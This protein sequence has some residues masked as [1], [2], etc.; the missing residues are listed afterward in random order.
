MKVWPLFVNC[1]RNRN[2]Y[3]NYS[4]TRVLLHQ[5]VYDISR[6]STS[7]MTAHSQ[8][9]FRHVSSSTSQNHVSPESFAVVYRF[10][11]I[12]FVRALSRLKLLQT[13][14]AALG[15]PTTGIL[16]NMQYIDPE[17]FYMMS[18]V[19]LFAC[20]MLYVMSELT[21]RAVGAIYIDPE[22]RLV[23]VSHLTFWGAR[24]NIIVPVDDI[25]PLADISEEPKNIYVKLK[26]YSTE[27]VLYFSIKY[28]LIFD[29][30][31][32]EL[33]FGKLEPRLIK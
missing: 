27:D 32:F 9:N 24:K 14:V 12:V 6:R 28:G 7:C 31:A 26:R 23:K 17:V 20:A 25:V 33:V 29:K 18:G 15:I 16:S 5:Y 30:E 22:R 4:N 10:P 2:I 13:G 21:R 19:G 11:Y 8:C 1:L 3:A